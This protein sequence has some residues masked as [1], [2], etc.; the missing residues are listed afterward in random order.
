MMVAAGG[1]RDLPNWEKLEKKGKND[2]GYSGTFLNGKI[3]K[4]GKNDI[5]YS[6]TFLNRKIWKK[7]GKK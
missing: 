3:W 2:I 7:K 4:K 5:G 1:S 6:G